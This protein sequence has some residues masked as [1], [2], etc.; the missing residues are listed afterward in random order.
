MVLLKGFRNR[1]FSG[2][3]GFFLKIVIFQRKW[4]K[5]QKRILNAEDDKEGK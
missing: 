4:A 1:A 3:S 2:L 5:S